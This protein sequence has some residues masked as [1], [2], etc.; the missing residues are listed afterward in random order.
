M[1]V[2][3]AVKRLRQT[4]CFGGVGGAFVAT[5][6]LG[7]ASL[8]TAACSSP[9]AQPAPASARTEVAAST[10]P[11]ARPA[12]SFGP[13]P[14]A[15]RR[16]SAPPGIDAKAATEGSVAPQFSLL[17]P[18]TGKAWSLTEGLAKWDYVVLVFYRGAW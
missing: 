10:A 8:A 7:A 1:S 3:A 18:V 5:A 6:I 16:D 14:K 4:A 11:S 15:A 9:G 2:A 12:S 17:A 13:F